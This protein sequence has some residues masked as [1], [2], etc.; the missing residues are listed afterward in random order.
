MRTSLTFTGVV[1]I[2]S[3]QSVACSSSSAEGVDASGGAGEAAN[4]DGATAGRSQELCD[5]SESIRLQYTNGGGFGARYS[6]FLHPLGSQYLFVD[7][8]CRF[9]V[10]TDVWLGTRVG[11]LTTEQASALE[12]RLGYAEFDAIDGDWETAGCFDGPTWT[13]EAGGA[14]ISCYCGCFDDDVPAEVLEM[15]EAID[16]V[17]AAL[18]VDG[19]DYDGPLRVAA[20]EITQ[21]VQDDQLHFDWQT[22][23]LAASIT[24]ATFGADTSTHD[25]MAGMP[26][27]DP[28]E[29]EAARA[30]RTEYV[31]SH[32]T[33]PSTDDGFLPVTADGAYYAVLMRDVVPWDPGAS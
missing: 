32:G 21:S 3:L 9:W 33:I 20:E 31:S 1:A 12:A 28:A 27:N 26:I 17:A 29:R 4:A 5:G 24:A 30:L 13:V 6:G 14:R 8:H 10:S 2:A 11:T 22:W 25:P 19:T 23:P 18:W 7:G 16:E 15:G